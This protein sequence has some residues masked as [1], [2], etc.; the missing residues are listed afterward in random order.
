MK[1]HREVDVASEF[2][3]NDVHFET[4]LGIWI[5][6]VAESFEGKIADFAQNH[7][8]RMAHNIFFRM[9]ADRQQK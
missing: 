6:T 2:V 4:W 3:I 8:V 5:P 9:M 1:V 7:A